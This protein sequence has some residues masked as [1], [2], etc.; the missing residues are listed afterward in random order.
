MGFQTV[1]NNQ[2]GVARAGDF[3]GAG[4][5]T[6][7]VGTPHKLVAAPAPNRPFIGSFC[8]TDQVSG[9]VYGNYLGSP[10]AK[11]GFL[12]N[13]T[14][15]VVVPFLADDQLYVEAGQ[16]ITPFNQGGFWANFPAG[17]TVGQKVFAN[18]LTGS[19]Y[20]ANAGT[21][22]QVASVTGAIAATTGVLTVSAVGSGTIANGDYLTGAQITAVGLAGVQVTGQLTGTLGGAGTYSTTYTGGTAITSGTLLATNAIETAFKVDTPAYAPCVFTGSISGVGLLTVTAI[23]SGALAVGQT[24]MA[25]AALP[26]TVTITSQVSGS[27]GSTGTYQTG[28]WSGLPLASTTITA[29]L[30]TLA[31]IST[32]G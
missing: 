14:Q 30:G 7:V 22:T 27:T 32:W 31:I 18:Y 5:R 9:L 21:S 23:A 16:P 12:H 26:T 11:I 13:D 28:P 2:P 3:A 25:S 24:L 15:I 10:T 1:I 4:V 17:A 29:S 19:V 8:W 6:V 20:A